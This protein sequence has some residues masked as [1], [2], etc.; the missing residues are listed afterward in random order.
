[1]GSHLTLSLMSFHTGACCPL[2]TDLSHLCPARPPPR[3]CHAMLV[4]MARGGAGRR[5][6]SK[7]GAWI[8]ICFPA[9]PG[10]AHP[11]A[12]Q[13]G[14]GRRPDSQSALIGDSFP[15]CPQ[16]RQVENTGGTRVRLDCALRDVL[17]GSYSVR[18]SK[19]R[20]R[21]EPRKSLG[22]HGELTTA[23]YARR[24]RGPRSRERSARV[25][26]VGGG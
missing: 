20:I 17:R 9:Q 26:S 6:G 13:P 15:F 4:A 7:C 19:A 10:V 22:L 12:A 24:F 8:G 3:T 16:V 2:S 18:W 5:R 14:V 21:T 23:N 11:G 1:M 25:R